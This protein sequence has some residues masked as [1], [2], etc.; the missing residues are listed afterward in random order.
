MTGPVVE[1]AID[2]MGDEVLAGCNL[3]AAI[4]VLEH[5]AVFFYAHANFFYATTGQ[6]AATH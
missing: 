5:P 3:V 1:N 6:S 2:D 4:Y